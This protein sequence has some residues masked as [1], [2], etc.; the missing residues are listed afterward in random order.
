MIYETYLNREVSEW[1]AGIRNEMDVESLGKAD[2]S[3]GCVFPK[4]SCSGFL[5][6]LKASAIRTFER[7]GTPNPRE[8]SP[9]AHVTDQLV[10]VIRREDLQF[11]HH[12]LADHNH[13]LDGMAKGEVIE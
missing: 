5:W 2:E 3:S 12:Q 13:G 8:I 9:F 6:R 11:S 10:E 4:L 1:R 7:Y